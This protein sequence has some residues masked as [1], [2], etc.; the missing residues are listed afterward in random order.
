MRSL[1]D[2]LERE[3]LI[4]KLKDTEKELGQV[5]SQQALA[6]VAGL[7]ESAKQIGDFKFLAAQIG[8]GIA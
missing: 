3:E 4:N 1:I 2:L 5:R 6:Q 7:L 8:D